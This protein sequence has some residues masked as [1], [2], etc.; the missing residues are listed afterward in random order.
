MHAAEADVTPGRTTS[1]PA[2]AA[3]ARADAPAAARG[4]FEAVKLKAQRKAAGAYTV[5]VG[6]AWACAPAGAPAPD[7][8][9]GNLQWRIEDPVAGHG[10][11]T[12]R[13]C[14]R[15]VQVARARGVDVAELV[16]L[17]K[18]LYP[19]INSR[20]KL[21]DGTRIQL[22]DP[23]VADLDADCSR[24]DTPRTVAARSSAP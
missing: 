20:S 8:L 1:T 16:N 19:G 12:P 22:A 23:A 10:Q 21:L 13:T 7:L 4:G 9:V 6:A 2:H 17:N 11:D 15:H 5:R 24:K 3:D 14:P 18:D